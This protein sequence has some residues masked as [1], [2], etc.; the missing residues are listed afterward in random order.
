MDGHGVVTLGKGLQIGI[1][2]SDD[3]AALF[4]GVVCGLG[5]LLVVVAAGDGNLGQSGVETIAFKH[6]DRGRT[7]DKAVAQSGVVLNRGH[8]VDG[9]TIG[10]RILQENGIRCTVISI[11]IENDRGG[12]FH[13]ADLGVGIGGINFNPVHAAVGE[14]TVCSCIDVDRAVCSKGCL[15]T[16]AKNQLVVSLAVDG[17]SVAQMVDDQIATGSDGT[18]TGD[19]KTIEIDNG[20][21]GGGHGVCGIEG[22]IFAQGI[23][24]GCGCL[25]E[26]FKVCIFAGAGTV[27][28]FCGSAAG[29]NGDIV[30]FSD[31]VVIA[32]LQCI[33]SGCNCRG[34]CLKAGRVGNSGSG[35]STGNGGS[36]GDSCGDSGL[37]GTALNGDSSAD[38]RIE[39]A[40][41]NG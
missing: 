3:G 26:S 33:A 31:D 11:G 34:L 29:A 5:Q 24:I 15:V 27:V 8:V 23:G 25:K 4:S 10:S 12:S 37:K 18:G 19:G 32:V 6:H 13:V 7:V 28:V 16:G 38:S 2:Q 17:I 40:A 1:L 22:F 21:T 14:S 41:S 35:G 36:D 20:F 39:G 9:Q 30:L